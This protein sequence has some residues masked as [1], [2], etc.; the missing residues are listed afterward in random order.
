MANLTSTQKKSRNKFVAMLLG[1]VVIAAAIVFVVYSGITSK[2]ALLDN[3]NFAKAM[4][5]ILD[6]KPIS[7]T[8]KDLSEIKYMEMIYADSYYM[9]AIGYDDFMTQYSK[10]EDDAAITPETAALL[11]TAVFEGDT[12]DI[13]TDIKYFTGLKNVI[14]HG[15]TLAQDTS[16]ASHTSLT[17]GTFSYT[18]LTTAAPFATLN[19]A[20]ITSLD[21]SNNSI[22]DYSALDSI[23]DKVTLWYNSEE[24]DEGNTTDKPFTLKEYNDMIDSLNSSVTENTDAEDDSSSEDETDKSET[25]SENAQ[26]TD[27][28]TADA[29]PAE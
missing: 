8:E 24:D 22:S 13:F 6:K 5:E 28:E 23:A 2:S 3:Q 4:A 10:L 9:L 17:E 19:L 21:L 7:I 27:V 1:I 29:A 16:F 15:V 12:D 20:N 26:D 25:D 18:G 14:L 11:K